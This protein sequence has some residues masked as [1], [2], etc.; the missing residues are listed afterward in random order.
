[1]YDLSTW[2][3]NLGRWGGLRVRLHAFFLV[4]AV[5]MLLVATQSG[6]TNLLWIGGLSIAVHFAIVALHELAHG[7]AA[8]RVGGHTDEIAIGPLGGMVR[9][10]VPHDPQRE[11]ITVLAGPAVN[12]ILA[13]LLAPLVFIIARVQGLDLFHPIAPGSFVP[14]MADGLTARMIVLTAFKL[15]FWL[16]WVVLLVNVLP[17]FPFDGGRF[18]RT[19]LWPAL[20][21]RTAVIW[22]ARSTKFL[23]AIFCLLA[24]LSWEVYPMSVVPAWVPLVLM[25]IYM[26]FSA[27]QEISRLENRAVDDDLFGYDFDEDHAELDDEFDDDSYDNFYDDTDDEFDDMTLVDRWREK[28]REQRIRQARAQEEAEEARV[29][30]I[31]DRLHHEG[32]EALSIEERA[33]L[34]RVSARYRL[35]LR[36]EA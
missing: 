34:S 4:A 9:L 23:A 2:S 22:V 29:D 27:N 20:G 13:I 16:N 36:N 18:L 31:L 24:W 10:H 30:R 11:L 32:Y 8:L 25:A 26:F 17:A 6:S 28:R 21:Y 5:F 14:I 33:L 35:R 7:Y 12:V 3:L 15:A 19:I 1:M